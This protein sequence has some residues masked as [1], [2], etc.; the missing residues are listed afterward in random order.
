MTTTKTNWKEVRKSMLARSEDPAYRRDI[1]LIMD[2]LV[3]YKYQ[4]ER[5]KKKL[6]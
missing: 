1:N 6:K 2:K 5:L 4:Y 3:A